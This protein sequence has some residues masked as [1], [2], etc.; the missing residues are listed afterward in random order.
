M[1]IEPSAIQPAP[2]AAPALGAATLCEAFQVTAAARPDEV[3]HRSLDGAVELT[4]AQYAGRVRAIAG[5]FHA[6]GVRRG[7][8]V[9]I[10]LVNR[11]EFNLVDSAA[12]HLGAAPFSLYNT[13]SVE[14]VAYQ[15]QNSQARVVVT[16]PQ[17]LDT[18]LAAR[19][20][21][22]EQVVLVE[23]S[24]PDA[25]GLGELETRAPD[26]FD[27][28][29]AW[30]AVQPDDVLTV[31]YTSGTTG[32]PKGAQ[33]THAGMMFE[34]RAVASVLP[35]TLGGRQLSYLPS[36]HIA[37]R[38]LSHYYASMCFGS[39][40]TSVPDIRQIGSALATVRPTAWGAVP[41][42]WEKLKAGLE[43]A[44]VGDPR[45]LTEEG[46]A[47]ARERLGLHE[48]EW[49]VSGAAPIP[50]EVLQYFLDLGLPI[51]EV[52]GMSEL[53]CVA[54]IVPPHDIRIGTVGRPL[55]GVELRVLDDGE[56]LVRAP[57]VMRGYRSDPERTA[58][59]LDA[60]GWMHTGDVV[61]IDADGFVRIVDRKKELIINAAGKNMS[62]ANIEQQLKA[63]SPLIGQAICVGDR[64]PYNVA[65]LVLDPD[66]AA[67]WA[68]AHG[69]DPSL[70]ALSANPELQA[71]V[72]TA[73]EAANGRLARVEQIKRFAILPDDWEPGGVELTPTMKL[74][75][76]PIAERYAAE[77]EALY[78]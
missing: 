25:I 18:V 1:T 55:P 51:C 62:P 7:D 26:G 73:V 36:A 17:Y 22:Q 8:C 61:E 40:V 59:A 16:E 45:A 72:A 11:P 56:L 21:D 15:L 14:Q 9:A 41:R 68:A 32:P 76:R 67:A 49:L 34:C 10:L 33:L 47:A 44:G 52:W 43:A 53:S 66:A 12:M 42:V 75:R 39:A 29:A 58:E 23:E 77:I 31:I 37:D 54:T 69:A 4:W 48:A 63:S 74:K 46:R 3:A 5:G 65:L 78:A 57:L 30:R 13:L 6:L 64:R 27:F 20:P 28:E 35:M 60:E 71:D 70:A 19:G 2:A 50:G 24:H 38:F